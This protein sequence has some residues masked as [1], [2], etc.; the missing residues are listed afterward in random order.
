MLPVFIIEDNGAQREQI[1]AAIRDYVMIEDLDIEIVMST[2]DPHGC[3]EYL[4]S[5]P[6]I[7]GL[8]FLDVDL[9]SD[10]DG[11]QLGE[12]IRELD[13]NGRIVMVTTAGTM[14]YLTFL[15]KLEV[16]DYIIKESAD[17]VISKIRNCLKIAYERYRNTSSRERDVIEVKIGNRMRSVPVEQVCF[18]ETGR[19]HHLNLSTMNGKIEF[20]GSMGDCSL[21]N[22][23]LLRTHR[24]YLVNLDN[25]KRL[26]E[27]KRLLEMKNGEFCHVSMSKMKE[28]KYRL[29]EKEKSI[30]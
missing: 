20:R 8:Y 24:A 3:I 9:K 28:V 25:V 17:I 6:G 18:I 4:E 12:K 1:E 19:Q 2:H 23:E 14:A 21:N 26:D 22:P 30:W 13:P 11:I 29:A 15:Y 7:R 5:K 10:I 16:L 27:E